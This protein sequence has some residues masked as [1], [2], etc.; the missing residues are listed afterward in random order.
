LEAENS[1]EG[2]AAELVKLRRE[3]EALNGAKTASEAKAAEALAQ[4]QSRVKTLEA[5]RGDTLKRSGQAEAE[6]AALSTKLEQL[7]VER[8][9]EERAFQDAQRRAEIQCQELEKQRD[10]AVSRMQQL[11][12]VRTAVKARVGKLSA[13]LSVQNTSAGADPKIKQALEST[14]QEL[15]NLAE[16]FELRNSSTMSLGVGMDQRDLVGLPPH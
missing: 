6:V 7:A 11:E 1:A 14:R 8:G 4:L 15:Q 10:S 16:Y 13:Y 2:P 9:V 5:E 12:E 3:F